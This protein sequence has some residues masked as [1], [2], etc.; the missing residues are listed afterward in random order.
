MSVY[1]ARRLASY[2]SAIASLLHLVSVACQDLQSRSRLLDIRN[3]GLGSDRSDRSRTHLDHLACV[4]IQR[5]DHAAAS[6][7][8][9]FCYRACEGGTYPNDAGRDALQV[10]EKEVVAVRCSQNPCIRTRPARKS[11][12]RGMTCLSIHKSG[13]Q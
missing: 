2:S 3:N 6:G 13:L 10:A 11:P 4:P 12:T 1:T 9:T 8:C 7:F 5:D